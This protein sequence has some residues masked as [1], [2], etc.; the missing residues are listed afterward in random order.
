MNTNIEYMVNQKNDIGE[1]R[2]KVIS[3]NLKSILVNI[4]K[5][6]LN[7]I[8]KMIEDS[9]ILS[10]NPR[11]DEID[12]GLDPLSW[13]GSINK[14]KTI[15]INDFVSESYWNEIQIETLIFIDSIAGLRSFVS[16]TIQQL[17]N[18]L[19]RDLQELRLNFLEE[20]IAILV[21]M[22]NIDLGQKQSELVNSWIDAGVRGTQTLHDFLE[23]KL[24]P[25]LNNLFD[26]LK[27][28]DEKEVVYYLNKAVFSRENIFEV[29]AIQQKAFNLFTNMPWYKKSLLD[30][31]I[32]SPLYKHIEKTK[33]E[34]LKAT[35]L[36]N[37][38]IL[39]KINKEYDK[40][41]GGY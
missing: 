36:Y 16:F 8:K 21:K 6:E 15:T 35:K 9:N 17:Y 28:D 5:K 41:F 14:P 29:L 1:E 10:F 32:I 7:K 30:G 22:S 20:I 12:Y 24:Y 26:S 19:D 38:A 37:E 11:F 33:I 18:S 39:E 3:D 27:I 4:D 31:I 23:N 40:E 25:W 13:S 2:Q 34:I